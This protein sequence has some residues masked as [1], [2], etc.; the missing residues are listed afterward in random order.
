MTDRTVV[1]TEIVSEELDESFLRSFFMD[2]PIAKEEKAITIKQKYARNGDL[3]KF[4]F[5]KFE[6]K[7]VAQK[8]IDELNYTKIDGV[9]IHLMSVE[10]EEKIRSPNKKGNLIVKH[11]D[12]DVEESQLHDAFSNFG[13]VISVK[14]PTDLDPK[15]R[16]RKPRSYAFVQY[17]DEDDAIVAIDELQ[18]AC[19]NGVPIIIERYEAR[20]Y[21]K[22]EDTFTNCYINNFPKTWTEEKLKEMFAVFGTPLSVSIIKNKNN[23]S[24]GAGFCSMSTHEEA[25]NACAALSTR[26]IEGKEIRCCRALSKDERKQEVQRN[27]QQFQQ[28]NHLRYG[29]RNLYVRFPKPFYEIEEDRLAELFSKFGQ[30]ESLKIEKTPSGQSKGFGFVCYKTQEEALHA[31]DES[32]FEIENYQWYVAKIRPKARKNIP[33]YQQPTVYLRALA[34]NHPNS[35]KLQSC[36]YYMSEDQAERICLINSLLERWIAQFD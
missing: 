31:L 21:Q 28:A 6:T 12:K 5:I 3:L 33:N 7:E 17:R 10:D 36:T 24:T 29:N 1:M 25:V 20:Q 26:I 34:S 27:T 4:A 2:F 14:I 30:I 22:P 8:A 16:E 18:G 19:I 23:E 15:T 13:Y 9:P 35:L 11:I 32:C